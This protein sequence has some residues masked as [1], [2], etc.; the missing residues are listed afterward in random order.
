MPINGYGAIEVLSNPGLKVLHI[1]TAIP[2]L[3]GEGSEGPGEEAKAP[4]VGFVGE[5]VLVGGGA[6]ADG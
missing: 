3:G 1:C 6:G 5:E 2:L 4:A